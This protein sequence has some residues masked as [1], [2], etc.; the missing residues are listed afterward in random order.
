MHATT[1][2]S[3]TQTLTTGLMLSDSENT[4]Y[5]EQ[6]IKQLAEALFPLF[7]DTMEKHIEDTI[8]SPRKGKWK[9]DHTKM[10]QQIKYLQDGNSKFENSLKGYKQQIS[11]WTEKVKSLQSHVN[12]IDS[13]RKKEAKQIKIGCHKLEEFTKTHIKMKNE[14]KNLDKLKREVNNVIQ[15]AENANKPIDGEVIAE[16]ESSQDFISTKLEELKADVVKN[17]EEMQKRICQHDDQI[18]VMANRV[19]KAQNKTENNSQY[20]RCDCAVLEKV[21][22]DG[23]EEEEM[24]ENHNKNLKKKCV[25]IFDELGLTVDPE[26]ISI[27]H[28]LK[29]S[30]HSKPGPRGI[31]M[32]FT[33]REVCHDVLQLRKVCKEKRTWNFDP[34]AGRIFLN[35]ALTPEK[36]KLLYDTKT[37]INKHLVQKHGIIYVWTY[38][39]NSYIRKNAKGAPKILIKSNWDLYNVIKGFTSLD[40]IPQPTHVPNVNSENETPWWCNSNEYPHPPR[41]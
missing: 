9:T 13:E 25:A 14:I 40:K 7:L 28:R 6:Q 34:K 39:G 5:S 29:E 21:P 19:D 11:T 2:T 15:N 16:V 18:K 31:I 26:K 20:L 32:K 4:Q 24:N 27:V 10:Q 3:S 41:Y 38:H 12:E 37:S 30:R 17:T 1:T 22:E 35:E 23:E 36:R 8:N 33:S